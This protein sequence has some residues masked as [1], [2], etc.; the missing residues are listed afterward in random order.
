MYIGIENV[1][2][3]V[4]EKGLEYKLLA[5]KKKLGSGFAVVTGSSS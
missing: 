4:K 1:S 5:R 3:R 2:M